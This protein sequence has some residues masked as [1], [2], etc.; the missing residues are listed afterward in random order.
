MRPVIR[1]TLTDE[2]LLNADVIN[3]INMFHATGVIKSHVNSKI[4]L[5]NCFDII[6]PVKE[7]TLAD[8]D[9]WAERCTNEINI[10]GGKAKIIPQQY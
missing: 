3:L 6:A 10:K 7:R 5:D 1:I 9:A 8:C 4:G 2:Q